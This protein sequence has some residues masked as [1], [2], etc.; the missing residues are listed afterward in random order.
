MPRL[1]PYMHVQNF[2]D[3]DLSQEILAYAI[4]HQNLYEQSQIGKEGKINEKVRISHVTRELGP[5]EAVVQEKIEAFYPKIREGLGMSDFTKRK[6]FEI[7]R[8][9]S[10]LKGSRTEI[11]LRLLQQTLTFAGNDQH[12]A[13]LSGDIKLVLETTDFGI[14][15]FWARDNKSYF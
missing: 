10:T 9:E 6:N 2:L 8:L 11:W 13:L 3:E 1:F 15:F 4:E 7:L 14:H 5:W 12:L